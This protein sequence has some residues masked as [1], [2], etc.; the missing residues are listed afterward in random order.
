MLR[1]ERREE[2]RRLDDA[3][4]VSDKDPGGWIQRGSDSTR[5]GR[6]MEDAAQRQVTAQ[7]AAK[8]GRSKGTFDF[9]H[10]DHSRGGGGF[11][12]VI[13]ELTTH[14][15]KVTAKIRIREV[16][17]HPDRYVSKS[18]FSAISGD[19]LKSNLG[20][21]GNIIQEARAAKAL[22][23]EVVVFDKPD[24]TPEHLDAMYEAFTTNNIEVEVVLGPDTLL[25][26]ANGT[27]KRVLKDLQN[28][29]DGQLQKGAF[30]T[31]PD[32]VKENW[33][34]TAQEAEK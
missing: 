34:R 18:E 24:L 2:I 25:G 21:L 23:P 27:G 7:L 12:N 8:K 17:D 31:N 4:N 33:V 19:G 30:K 16:K 15:D 13:V 6:I 9:V 11:D 20:V 22:D 1:H 14:G 5:A 10:I 29:V 26:S 3:K 28:D 32:R